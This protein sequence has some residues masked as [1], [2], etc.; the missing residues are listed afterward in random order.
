MTLLIAIPRETEPG[1]CRVA[2]TPA[3]LV[4]VLKLGTSVV[5]ETGAGQ[6]AGFTDESFAGAMIARSAAEAVAAADIV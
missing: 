5:I 2:M 6:A 1:E 4:R 3:T